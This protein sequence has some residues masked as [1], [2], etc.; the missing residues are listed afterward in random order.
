METQ[1]DLFIYVKNEK[2]LEL[3]TDWLANRRYN[4]VRSDGYDK[5]GQPMIG[6]TEILDKR[7][8]EKRGVIVCMTEE[9]R[10]MARVIVA[11]YMASG[12][13]AA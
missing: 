10:D 3:L 11:K 5:K 6:L 1:E 13:R 8:M 4:S 7:T 12:S 2:S 9:L